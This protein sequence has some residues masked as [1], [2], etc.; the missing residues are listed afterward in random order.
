MK[1]VVANRRREHGV[2]VVSIPTPTLSEAIPQARIRVQL[3]GIC[4]TDVHIIDG[5]RD[6]Q[7]VLGHEFVGLVES[8]STEANADW[9]GA[10]V[11]GEINLSCHRCEMCDMGLPRH[12]SRRRVLGIEDHP[13]CFAEF[14]TL[15]TENLHRVPDDL[16]SVRAVWT[17]PLAAALAVDETRPPGWSRDRPALIIGDGRLGLLTALA[18]SERGQQVRL[19]GKHEQRLERARRWGVAIEEGRPEHQYGWVVE[20]TGRSDGIG[21]ARQWAY[22]RATIVLKSTGHEMSPVDASRI[23]VD[24]LTIVGSRCGAFEPSLKL[25]EAMRLE[26]LVDEI[27]PLDQAAHALEAVR[28][29]AFKIL[30]RP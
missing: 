12:C 6:Y 20:A 29:G 26:S 19:R 4:G 13:G 23:V 5:Y 18:L 3:A 2:D 21:L 22:P 30:L 28:R 16:D 17:E 10:R 11:V 15:P 25:L 27:V 1:A 9:V 7:G 24:E 14:V 8:V